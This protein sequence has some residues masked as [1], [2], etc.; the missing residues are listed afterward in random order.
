MADTMES[1]G[2]YAASLG[3][4][5]KKTVNNKLILPQNFI[6]QI[7]YYHEKITMSLENLEKITMNPDMQEIIMKKKSAR[8]YPLLSNLS[9]PLKM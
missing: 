7:D 4:I 2:D 6:N 5:Y 3:K 9:T 8:I 1:L